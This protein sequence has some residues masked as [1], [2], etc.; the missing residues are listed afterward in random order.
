M[1]YLFEI[2]NTSCVFNA[3]FIS[4]HFVIEFVYQRWDW[5]IDLIT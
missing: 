2:T 4:K 5:G 1:H 3:I